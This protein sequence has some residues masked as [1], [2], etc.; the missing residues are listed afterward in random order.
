MAYSSPTKTNVRVAPAPAARLPRVGR[1]PQHPFNLI[2]KPYQ[3]QPFFIAPVLPG[4][5]LKNMMLQS[6]V[7]S[8]PLAAGMKNVGW[9]CEYNVFYV[10]HQHLRGW[11]DNGGTGLAQELADMFVSNGNLDSFRDMDGNAWSYCYPGAVDYVFE[12]T[13]RIVDEYFRDEGEN[14]DDQLLDGVPLA[15]IYSKGRSDGFERL[16][17]NTAYVD[18]S[19]P[20]PETW[21]DAELS[22]LEWASLR[23][24]GQI[25]MDYDDWMRTYGSNTHRVEEAVQRHRPE[26][27]AYLR[28]FTYPNNTVE[29][30]TGVPATAVGW[31]IGRRLDKRVFF[32]EPGWIV[33]FN[34]IKPKVYLANQQ[35]TVTGAMQSRATWLP[36]VLGGKEDQGHIQFTDST[37]P[38]AGIMDAGNVPYW[39]DIKDLLNNG[40]Q[41]VNYATPAAGVTGVPFVELPLAS[42]QRRY[43]AATEIMAMFADTT[44]GRLRQDGMVSLSIMGRAQQPNRSLALGQGGMV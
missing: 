1:R 44:N 25:D 18:R 35:G 39:L 19:E 11:D 32:R 20:L 30:T 15:K 7:W 43:A 41:F 8:D 37:G 36:P 38:L 24:G 42:G 26:D 10:S 9:W 28:E 3:I 27:I 13:K 21:D 34:T 31:R 22:W 33:G 29:P 17:L 12:C 40:E 14:W 2:T 16:T 5:T 4:E 23:D 6:Q